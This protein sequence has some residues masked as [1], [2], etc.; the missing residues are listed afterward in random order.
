MDT[1]TTDYMRRRNA[2]VEADRALR[3]DATRLRSLSD[4]ET[5]AEAAVRTIRR[6]E[7]AAIW[8][9]E[10]SIFEYDPVDRTPN[11]FPGMAFLTGGPLFLSGDAI[12]ADNSFSSRN[13]DDNE[14][15]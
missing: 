15:V 14:V 11:V 5:R 4:V 1:T 2:L 8:G 9:A 13:C 6:G 10:K 7:A 3:I 12:I